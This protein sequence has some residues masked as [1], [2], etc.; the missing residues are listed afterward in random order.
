MRPAPRG[1]APRHGGRALGLLVLGLHLGLGLALHHLLRPAPRGP[2]ASAPV[3]VWITL[4]PAQR[5]A[6]APDAQP[7]QQAA[8]RPAGAAGAAMAAT[9][10]PARRAE[11]QAISL[12]A[13]PP[14][15]ATAATATAAPAAAEAGMPVAASASAPAAL[16]LA[17][18]GRAASA[19]PAPNTWTRHD[20]RVHDAALDGDQ[21]MARRLGTDTT[22]R[23]APRGDG[24]E[25]RRGNDC[26][27]V[28][29]ARAGQIFMPDGSARPPSQVGRC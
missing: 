11:P 15:P 2:A 12:P 29:P 21:R 24:F 20:A 7:R 25:L 19:P 13:E 8:P 9:A 10:A 26:V 23:T 16:N 28:Q 6:P 17:L 1:A 3:H 27:Q 14:A 18:P 5:P 4:A 22:L